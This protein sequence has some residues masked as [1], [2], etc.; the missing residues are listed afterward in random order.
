MNLDITA[1][2][3]PKLKWSAQLTTLTRRRIKPVEIVHADVM[4]PFPVQSIRK[5][6][7]RLN[8][9]DDETGDAD[10]Y[11]MKTM[12]E[13]LS[14]V[15]QHV[16]NVTAQFIIFIAIVRVRSSRACMIDCCEEE[17]CKSIVFS[18][19]KSISADVIVLC[20]PHWRT[21]EHSVA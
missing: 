8:L 21:A 7:Y 11:P 5:N 1:K 2:A 3:A 15:V 13:S 16:F 14:A 17:A 9:C 4:G 6:Q 20:A 18:I 10:C 12:D 19:T